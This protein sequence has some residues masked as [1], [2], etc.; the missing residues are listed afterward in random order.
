[1]LAVLALLEPITVAV[2]FQDMNVLREP[3]EQ[4]AGTRTEYAAPAWCGAQTALAFAHHARQ[5]ASHEAGQFR[6]ARWR[7]PMKKMFLAAFTVLSLAA[8]AV[9]P[10]AANAAVFHNGSTVAGDAAATRMQQTGSYSE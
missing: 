6:P 4:A 9:A 1:M 10:V 5:V 3:V 8:T 7:V 2:H